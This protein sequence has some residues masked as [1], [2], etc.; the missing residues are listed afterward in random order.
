[1]NGEV[2]T[3]RGDKRPHDLPSSGHANYFPGEET[4]DDSKLAVAIRDELESADLIVTW[5]G[6]LHDIP[7]LNARLQVGGERPYK[8]KTWPKGTHID[9][10]YFATGSALKIGSKALANVAKFFNLE[11]QKT[12]LDGKIWQRAAAGDRKAMS[13]IVEHCEADV[14]TMRDAFPYLAEHIKK[15]QLPF[16]CWWK[17]LEE[18]E[19]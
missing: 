18:I 9:L 14:L 7:L 6:I 11:H 5:N 17:W 13:D 12:P 16:N 15:L 2:Y 3:F 10:M 4:I 1:M 8:N 19:L